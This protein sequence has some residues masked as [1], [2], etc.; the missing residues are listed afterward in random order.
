LRKKNDKNISRRDFLKKS[1]G[2]LAALGISTLFIN[3]SC[4]FTG[5]ELKIGYIPI[6][7]AAPL[8]AAYHNGYFKEEGLKTAA[9]YLIRSWASLVEAFLADKVNVVHFLL[10][11]PIWMRYGNFSNVKIIAWN[12]TDGSAL[13]VNPK[14]NIKSFQDLG[15]RQ[16]AVPFWYSMHN[17]ILQMGLRKFGLKAV[18]K[19]QSEKLKSDETNLFILPPSEMPVALAADK[20]DGYIVAEPFNA[21]GEMKAGA[22]ILRFTGDIWKNHPCCVIVM[23]EKLIRENPSFVQKVTNAIVRAQS[24]MIKNKNNSAKILSKEGGGYLPVPE[25]VLL[26]VFNGYEL[27]KYGKGNTPVAIK[28][29]EWNASRIDFQPYPYPSATRFIFDNMKNTIVEGDNSFLKKHEAGFIASDLVDERFV[30][31][32]IKNLGGVNN[33]PVINP[34]SPWEREEVIDV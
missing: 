22:K 15:G 34:A 7:D 26:R 11:I 8:L 19:P 24:W 18:I 17:V 4:A 20:I 33:F 29:P 23:K 27:E 16:I 10:P 28:H 9:P 12:H 5:D 31:N 2:T 21:L 25:E 3:K 1:S 32:A 30:K 14:R 13:T 6:T